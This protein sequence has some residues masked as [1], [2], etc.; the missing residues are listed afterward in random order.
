MQPYYMAAS[1]RQDLTGKTFC[2][3][4]PFLPPSFGPQ[5]HQKLHTKLG[6]AEGRNRVKL[7]NSASPAG[8]GQGRSLTVREVCSLDPYNRWNTLI[9]EMRP[10]QYTKLTGYYVLLLL[11]ESGWKSYRTT[12]A[13]TRGKRR[14]CPITWHKEWEEEEWDNIDF[15]DTKRPIP[16]ICTQTVCLS[17]MG[18]GAV[19]IAQA[20]ET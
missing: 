9:T 4:F 17:T 2:S 16:T 10:L 6:E 15:D 19:E 7:T 8:G 18:V 12:W 1:S 13:S 3:P 20:F 11:S 14:T 5:R